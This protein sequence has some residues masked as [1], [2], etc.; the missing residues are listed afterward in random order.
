MGE[1]KKGGDGSIDLESWARKFRAAA[2]A[3]GFAHFRE[4]LRRHGLPNRPKLLLDGTIHF[5]AMWS[6]FH[7]LDRD[8]G[9]FAQVLRMQTYSPPTATKSLYAC[10]F[11][12]FGK[13]YARVF[14]DSKFST[15]DLADM[16]DVPWDAYQV[17][18]YSE[19]FVSR[20]D[21]GALTRKERVSLQTGVTDDLRYDFSEDELRLDFVEK[22]WDDF[23]GTYLHVR[24][25]EISDCD[26]ENLNADDSVD[27]E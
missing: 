5:V 3:D 18:G 12:L 15:L 9:K 23:D 8:S 14:V 7:S 22:D 10:T 6:G 20:L 1:P 13:A 26:H 19:F 4:H 25:R 11:N 21:A 2:K 17:A 16:F 27:I 24:L